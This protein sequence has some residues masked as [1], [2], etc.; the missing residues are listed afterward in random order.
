MF[1][2][3]GKA[4]FALIDEL[5]PQIFHDLEKKVRESSFSFILKIKSTKRAIL[6]L[7]ERSSC[8]FFFASLSSDVAS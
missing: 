3:E 4:L 6:T 2:F 5:N 7:F 1:L 8:L